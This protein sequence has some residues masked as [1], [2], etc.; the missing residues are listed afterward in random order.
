[1][2]SKKPKTPSADLVRVRIRGGWMD[3]G[4]KGRTIG[5][6]K[7]V[8]GTSWTPLVWDGEEDP[9]FFKTAGLTGCDASPED[10][11]AEH[12]GNC[13]RVFGP[14]SAP[15]VNVRD[16][17]SDQWLCVD[18]AGVERSKLPA[19]DPDHICGV[20]C[21]G[22]DGRSSRCAQERRAGRKRSKR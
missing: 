19:S 4:R 20:F 14:G 5:P 12:C 7:V 9:D 17:L 18:C 16:L 10:A 6:A 21:D 3:A 11:P 22:Q 13:G 2:K 8:N 1:M 15:Y